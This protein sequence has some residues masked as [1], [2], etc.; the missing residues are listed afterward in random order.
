MNHRETKASMLFKSG[1]IKKEVIANIGWQVNIGR[2]LELCFMPSEAAGSH[3]GAVTV[4]NILE[5]NQT[6]W[7]HGCE[8]L[9]IAV[10]PT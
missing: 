1:I 2:V 10:T 3:L 7:F 8:T 5:G 9:S 4:Q 6:G